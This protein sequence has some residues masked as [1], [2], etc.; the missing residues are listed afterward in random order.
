LLS[1]LKTKYDIYIQ[2]F[3]GRIVVRNLKTGVENFADSEAFAHPRIVIGDFDLAVASLRDVV[4]RDPDLKKD[5]ISKAIYHVRYELAGGL[6]DLERRIIRDS[7]WDS[8][9][10]EVILVEDPAELSDSQ[11]NSL[12]G[13]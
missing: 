9:G 11:L 13:E 2:V 7:S 3:H 6:T 10:T 4:S 12:I 8:L 1:F 5:S